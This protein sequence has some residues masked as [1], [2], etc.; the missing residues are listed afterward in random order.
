MPCVEGNDLPPFEASSQATLST[1]LLR[2]VPIVSV[3]GSDTHPRS[4]PG[5]AHVSRRCAGAAQR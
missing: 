1:L 2:A 5:P 4:G 3:T